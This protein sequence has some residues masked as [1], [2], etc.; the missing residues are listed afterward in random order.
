MQELNFFQ[1]FAIFM[2]E[3]GIY[4]YVILLV[5][6]V[7]IAIALER[8]LRYQLYD[9][10]ASSLLNELQKFI[11]ANDFKEA[12]K[13]CSKSRALLP[14]V[15]KHGLKRASHGTEQIQNAIDA[16]TLEV[17]PLVEKRL[18]YLGLLANV[19]T[20]FG[21][22]GTIWG[23]IDAFKAVGNAD[24][25]KK[26]EIL[27]KGIAVAMNTTALGLISAI[28]IMVIHAWLTAKSEK[29]IGEIDEFSVKLMDLLG[30][31]NLVDK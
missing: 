2:Q 18:A 1:E 20:L 31:K 17:I 19:S 15:I 13:Y 3:G 6:L 5:Y 30:T 11:L 23:L 28:S 21:L 12:I 26:A 14:R 7:G 10:K 8:F 16:T 4:M 22:L 27:S 25:T 24:P 29:I 9:I